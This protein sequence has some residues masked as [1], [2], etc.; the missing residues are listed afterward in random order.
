MTGPTRLLP[1]ST[2]EGKPCF[3]VGSGNGFVSR[4]ADN[5]E[6]SQLDTA[7][8][9]VERAADMLDDPKAAPEQLRFLLSRLSESLVEVIRVADSRG[10]RL[11]EPGGDQ[12]DDGPRLPAEA[13]G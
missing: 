11:L 8:D 12:G 13:F 10:A 5:I 7:G 3:L 6:R 9:L 2:P 4:M 1:W